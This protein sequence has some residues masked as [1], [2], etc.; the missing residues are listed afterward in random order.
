[1]F[2]TVLWVGSEAAPLGLLMLTSIALDRSLLLWLN[3]QTSCQ[4][5]GE[6]V[7]ESSTPVDL[8][9]K[10]TFIVLTYVPGEYAETVIG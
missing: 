7:G 2:W 8:A 1:V 3:K 5:S 9:S 10:K 6:G 4:V